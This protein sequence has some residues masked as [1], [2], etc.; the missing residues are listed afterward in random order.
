MNFFTILNNASL[1][2]SVAGEAGKMAM[3]YFFPPQ[4]SIIGTTVQGVT[5]VALQNP[6][7]TIEVL[8]KLVT[9]GVRGLVE[10]G[11]AS[12]IRSSLMSAAS[13]GVP[14]SG[15]GGIGLP[16]DG[17]DP[18]PMGFPFARN[19]GLLDRMTSDLMNSLGIQNSLIIQ[20]TKITLIILSYVFINR[21]F[22]KKPEIATPFVEP[23]PPIAETELVSFYTPYLP[24]AFAS[25]L[26]LGIILG[27]GIMFIVQKHKEKNDQ[28]RLTPQ[29]DDIIINPSAGDDVFDNFKKT[30]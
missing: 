10:S 11:P 20:S 30:N 6:L 15:H 5:Y 16:P 9:G 2:V 14:Q 21:I 17:V 18:G 24:F 23:P 4:T 22:R 7:K 26:S 12:S 27:S 8:W 1:L 29:S 28:M 19:E 3:T 13:S 25:I